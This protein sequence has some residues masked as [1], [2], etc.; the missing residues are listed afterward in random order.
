MK[1]R[2]QAHGFC[3]WSLALSFNYDNTPAIAFSESE[4]D[5]HTVLCPDSRARRMDTISDWLVCE[6]GYSVRLWLD[7]SER[8]TRPQPRREVEA[9]TAMI[10]AFQPRPSSTR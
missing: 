10:P 3:D 6:K 4:Y 1:I 5:Q 9:L 8:S 2:L 7:L